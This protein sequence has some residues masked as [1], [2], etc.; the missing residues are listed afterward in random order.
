[1]SQKELQEKMFRYQTLEENFNQLNQRRE[2]FTMKLIEIEQTKQAI[3]ELEK[4]KVDDVFVPLGSSVF[5][6]GKANKKERM[7][8]GIG[9]DIV[10]EKEMGEVK[11]TLE[12]RK[13]T[14]EN[15]LE[16]VQTNMVRIAQ[17][18]QKIQSEAE[19]LVSN[20]KAG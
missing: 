11:K 12:E 3:D 9:S 18:M 17:E 5:L 16:N 4:S 14:I 8:L 6:P 20:E 19:G 15:G 2:L 7:I 13:K 1:M 10:V